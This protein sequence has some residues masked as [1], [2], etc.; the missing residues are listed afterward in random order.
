[1]EVCGWKDEVRS[2]KDEVVGKGLE[3]CGKRN[4]V[5]RSHF[6]LQTSQFNLSRYIY[7][8]L[9]LFFL[10]VFIEVTIM[11]NSSFASLIKGFI[12]LGL[13]INTS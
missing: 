1:M 10:A 4:E 6:S 13:G 7:R 3:L 11:A 12:S 5:R 9:V 2:T 8:F